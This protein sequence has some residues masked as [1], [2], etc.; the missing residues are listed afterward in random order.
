M[1]PTAKNREVEESIVASVVA[2]S[3][4]TGDTISPSTIP[5]DK[6][7]FE[8]RVKSLL[9]VTDSTQS[10]LLTLLLDYLHEDLGLS[11]VGLILLSRD[12]SQLSLRASKGMDDMSAPGKL[13]LQTEK[14]GLL[15]TL[16]AKP[17]G[18][19]LEPA[20]YLKYEKI[21]P[22]RFKTSMQSE[23]FYLMSLFI[24]AKPVGLLYGDRKSMPSALDKKSYDA[25]KS[26]ILLTSK[27]LVFQHKRKRQKAA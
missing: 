9:R 16:L 20:S 4:S 17:Q 23:S 7:N 27:A 3:S 25:F 13:E 12:K 18:L 19:W 11:R 15:K 26:A 14:A 5:R 1:L 2:D 10:Q 22:A 6:P 24:S 8:S 21:I